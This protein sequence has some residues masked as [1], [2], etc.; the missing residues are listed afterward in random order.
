MLSKEENELLTRVGPGTPM[1]DLLRQYWMPLFLSSELPGPDGRPLRTRLLGEDLVA[2]RDTAGR[3]GLV[4]ENC[5]HRGA[6][7]YFGRNEESGLRCVYHGWKFDVSGSCVDM[8]NEPA[9]SNFK[10]K[11]HVIAYPAQERNGVI[12]AYM[13][14]RKTPPAL[15]S[16][17]WNV[18]P[19]EHSVKWK[20]MRECNWVQGLEGDIDTSHLYFL[21]G[22][23]N[24]E[25]SPALGVWHPDRHPRLELVPTEYGVK[26]AARRDQDADNYYWRITQ[27]LM[28]IYAYFPPGGTIGVPGHIWVPV[29]DEHTMVWSVSASPD[30][31]VSPQ[32]REMLGGG[33]GMDYLP[34]T[35]D[36]LGHWR[37]A[38]NRQNDYS[39]DYEVQR[40]KTFTGIKNIF[41]QDQCVTETMGPIFDRSSEHLGTT[42][43]M[44][45][46]VRKRLMDTA[47]ALRESGVTPDGVD[48]P[49]IY[50]VRS[51]S[52]VLP[53]AVDWI[54]GSAEAVRAFSG[55]PVASA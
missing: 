41:L 45:I 4:A 8:P 48:A 46:Q 20:A 13:G 24:P 16:M 19:E 50:A 27:F 26:Y 25:D 23:L 2:F 9:E 38:D 51:A 5:P 14:P 7:L 49:D 44:I 53:K 47:R 43:A 11:V 29:D 35:S 1:G 6:S 21:H 55:T 39:R 15:P 54:T 42:D 10:D 3:L 22:R 12:W 36:P 40:T 52:L 18:L 31:P 30:A 37:L 28:P 34:E 33:R 17:E 32:A